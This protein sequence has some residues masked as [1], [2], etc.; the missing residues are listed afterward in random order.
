M[1]DLLIAPCGQL[2]TLQHKS[3]GPRRGT[4]MRE[5]GVIEGGA[6]GIDT[7]RG[8]IEFAGTQSELQPEQLAAQVTKIDATDR[9]VMPG[10]VDSHTHIVHAGERSDEFYRR[11]RGESYQAIAQA[12]GGILNTVLATRAASENELLELAGR[13]IRM[14]LAN[15]TTTI[16]SKSGYGL[17]RQAEMKCLRVNRR[18]ADSSPALVLSTFMGA[19]SIP[20]EFADHRA[21]YIEALREMA[22]E[23]SALGVADFTDIF[24]DPLAF[25]RAEAEQIASQGRWAGLPLKLHADEFGD[26]GTAA[27]GVEQ[28]AVSVDHLA[29]IGAAGIEAL[30]Q[31]ETIATL[32]PSTMFFCKTGIYA[33]ARKMIDAGCAVALAS[34]LNPGSSLVYSLPFVMSLA[35]LHMGMSA[36]ECITA[37]TINGAYALR[38]AQQTG[39]LEAGK[40]ADVLI[41]DLP[42]YAQL[43]YHIGTDCISDVIANGVFV[44]RGGQMQQ[45]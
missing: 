45:F 16:E 10:F 44:K 42:L 17:E 22:A 8:M 13:R 24:V 34:D 7:G 20:P 25:T 6:L 4:A 37:A 35:V 31:S 30:S 9:V 1:I 33:P 39:S 11:A 36:E 21:G 43:P 40:R 26:D 38:V 18:L 41:L 14:L 5:L 12:G 29:G 15:G 19:H 3:S 2:V 23:A 27:W 28:N 32:L